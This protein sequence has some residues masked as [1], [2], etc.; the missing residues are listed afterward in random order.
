MPGSNIGELV[1]DAAVAG[2]GFS[3]LGRLDKGMDLGL[4]EESGPHD[5]FMADPSVVH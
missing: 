4:N 5:G 3:T 1:R 2:T